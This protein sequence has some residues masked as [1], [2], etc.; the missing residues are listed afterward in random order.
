MTGSRETRK[1]SREHNVDG[2]M[3]VGDFGLL[4]GILLS[5][6]TWG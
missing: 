2:R 4:I 3:P 5:Y 6:R 1:D